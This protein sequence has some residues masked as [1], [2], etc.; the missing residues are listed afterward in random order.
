MIEEYR[1]AWDDREVPYLV[2]DTMVSL[3][4]LLHTHIALALADIAVLRLETQD[5][6]RWTVTYSPEEIRDLV[7]ARLGEDLGL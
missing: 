7:I 6:Y 5:F 1:S 3:S 4:G 2:S